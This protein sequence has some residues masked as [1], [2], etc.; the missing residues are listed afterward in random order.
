MTK[1][2]KSIYRNRK[3]RLYV[4]LNNGKCACTYTSDDTLLLVGGFKNITGGRTNAGN[5]KVEHSIL[6]NE[7]TNS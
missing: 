1:R 2:N 5:A 4:R 6:R 3:S 7:S